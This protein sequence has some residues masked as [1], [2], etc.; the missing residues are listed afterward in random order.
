M[1]TASEKILEKVKK[2]LDQ[3][4]QEAEIKRK[5]QQSKIGEKMHL[6]LVF[7]NNQ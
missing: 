1:L 2:S 5:K 4:I 3:N 7:R 6:I